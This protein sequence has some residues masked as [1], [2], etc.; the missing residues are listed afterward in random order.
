L[1]GK[2]GKYFCGMD[3][4]DGAPPN[5]MD[6]VKKASVLWHFSFESLPLHTLPGQATGLAVFCSFFFFPVFFSRVGGLFKL[7][8]SAWLAYSLFPKK[9]DLFI[10]TPTALFPIFLSSRITI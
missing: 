4:G 5:Q 1:V 10:T 6:P 9:H 7:T 8:T 3:L 2:Y